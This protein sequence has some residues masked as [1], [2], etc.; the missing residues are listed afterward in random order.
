MKFTE[1]KSP[2]LFI[3]PTNIHISNELKV[4]PDENTVAQYKQ[5]WLSIQSH[6][7]YLQP[8]TWPAFKVPTRYNMCSKQDTFWAN[9]MT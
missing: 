9:F 7:H 5:K 4:D 3:R 8:K 1:T 2:T 6:L